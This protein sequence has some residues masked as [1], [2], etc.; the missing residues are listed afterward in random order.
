LYGGYLI[1][2]F[3]LPILLLIIGAI[4][5]II[6]SQIIYMLFKSFLF[7]GIMASIL[8]TSPDSCNNKKITVI[9]VALDDKPYAIVQTEQGRYFVDRL[10]A[11]DEKYYGKKVK[12]TGILHIEQHKKQSTDSVQVQEIVGTIRSIKRAK[13]ELA[14]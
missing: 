10:D 6:K 1:G 4:F 2:S 11:W 13:W 14:E 12:V 5:Q 3:Y 9:G 8:A 7:M